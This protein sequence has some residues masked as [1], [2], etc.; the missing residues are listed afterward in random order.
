MNPPTTRLSPVTSFPLRRALQD[1]SSA[2]HVL[3]NQFVHSNDLLVEIDPADF[4]IPAGTEKAAQDSEDSNFKAAVAGYELMRSR[5]DGRG[6]RG[7][8]K[9]DATAAEATANQGAIRF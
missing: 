2:V 9:A 8:S 3:D 7:K 4:A 5:Y 1:R 6:L